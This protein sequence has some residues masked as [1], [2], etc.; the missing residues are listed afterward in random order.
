M[1]PAITVFGEVLWDMLPAGRLAG[2]AP[3]NV[4]VHLHRY[5]HNV[6]FISRVG[7]DDPGSDLTGYMQAQG[8]STEWVQTGNTHLTGMAKANIRDN[9]EVTYKILHPVAW[10]YIQPDEKALNA[11]RQ[12]EWF[13]YGT[14]ASRDATT[15]ATLLSYLS[16]AR[17]PVFDAN[18]RP[19][20]YSPEV[21]LQLMK[22]AAI[23][24]LNHHELKEICRWLAPCSD[25]RQGMHFLKSYFDLHTLLVT[26]GPRG[27][28]ALTHDGSFFADDGF[29]VE[30]EDTIGSGDAFLAAFLHRIMDNTCMKHALE[31]ACAA[32]AYVATQPGALPGSVQQGTHRLI[33]SRQVGA[34]RMT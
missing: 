1:I 5:G 34:S 11:V 4:A 9:G 17:M 33:R 16:A 23:V 15:R 7:S 3:M 24:K 14:L 28:A 26:R 8:L 22:H 29:R 31:Y 10:D 30:V 12:S 2:G 27:A 20:H 25:L 6:A 18:L 21:V 19:P 32:G 13:V